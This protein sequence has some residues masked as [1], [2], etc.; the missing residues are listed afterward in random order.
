MKCK[1]VECRN[2]TIGKRVY[3]SLTCRN[4]YVNKYMRNYDKVK[5]TYKNKREEAEKEY[6]KDPKKCKY[7]DEIIIY[8]KR[9]ND[10]CGHSCVA[11]STNSSRIYDW[12]DKIKEG[13]DRYLNINGIERYVECNNCGDTIKKSKRR[14]YCSDKCMVEYRRKDM[15]KYK[16]YKLDTNFKFSL[17]DY[18]DEFDFSLIE[19]HG[20]YSPTNKKNNLDGVSRDH[21]I[22]VKDGF[23]KGIDPFLLSHPANCQLMIHN[24][25]VSKYTNSHMS[26]N[27]LLE[28]IE[29]WNEKYKN[30]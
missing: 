27:E 4:V 7:C 29:K 25:N 9:T 15:D 24:E 1:N 10:Y 17:N 26:E 18:P 21:I 8:E 14:K 16:K 3:C 12:G 28:K 22:S 30:E 20:W 13:I 23:E 6:L 5:E 19:K 2:E 11:S